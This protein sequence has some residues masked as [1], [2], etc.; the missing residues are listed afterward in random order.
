MKFKDFHHT[1]LKWAIENEYIWK[2]RL[3]NDLTQ[4]TIEIIEGA[5]ERFN[6]MAED[7]LIRDGRSVECTEQYK[8]EF[9]D[10]YKK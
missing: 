5:Y 8:K 1:V 7:D 2:E 10:Y 3:E 6:G 4:H 9:G